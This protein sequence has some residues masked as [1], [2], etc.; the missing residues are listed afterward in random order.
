MSLH[1]FRPHRESS[2][3]R[4]THQRKRSPDAQVFDRVS[5]VPATSPG[6]VVRLM[7]QTL[8]LLLQAALLAAV[9]PVQPAAADTTLVS[10]SWHVIYIGDKRVG[11]AR[12]TVTSEPAGDDV[13]YHS[14]EETKLKVQRFGQ[15]IRMNTRQSTVETADGTL[16][17]FT[18]TMDNPPA[19]STQTV[20]QVD[21]D[22]L[23]LEI[24]EAGRV[25]RRTA[26]WDPSAKTPAWQAR[27]LRLTPLRPGEHRSFR[28]YVPQ[29]NKV[30]KVRIAADRMRSVRLHDGSR[31]DLLKATVT[32]FILPKFSTRIWIDADGST[33]KTEMDFLGMMMTTYEV[34]AAVAMEEIAGAELDLAVNTLVRVSPPRRFGHR[35][36]HAVYQID[37]T[38]RIPDDAIAKGPTQQVKRI[39]ADTVEVT[40]TAAEVPKTDRRVAID[41]DFTR[42]TRFLQVNDSRVAYHSNRAAAGRTRPWEIAT[43]MERYVNRELRR[44][45]F[46][47]ALASAAEV[48]ETLQGDC[49]E[50]SVLLAAMLRNK[51]IPSRVAVGLVYVESQGAF[52]GHMWTEAFLDGRWIS[53]DATL[54]RGGI[55]AAHIKLATSSLADDAP[56]PITSFLPLID[57]LGK[58]SIRI[59]H[60]E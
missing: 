21:G 40:V 48:A 22:K 47:T 60:A 11:Y 55:G 57:I 56:S 50:H 33:L 29:F 59:L 31:R 24:H 30:T 35:T 25:D 42:G 26:S 14:T 1:Q 39:D 12:T 4:K 38:E 13:I 36:R 28:M 37:S 54:G 52:G 18:L 9:C 32:Q 46:F 16:L 5:D 17:S 2:C 41:E 49:T 27:S 7:R 15:L 58:I 43:R 6:S 20:G 19:K 23:R 8:T 53:L 3:L 51:R 45:N 44:K 34:T 10:D